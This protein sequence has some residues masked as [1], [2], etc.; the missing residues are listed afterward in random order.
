MLFF[1]TVDS[2]RGQDRHHIRH[3]GKIYARSY[4]SQ[5]L[6]V[7]LSKM[8]LVLHHCRLSGQVN[9]PALRSGQ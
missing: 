9:Y 6:H 4:G 5:A 8:E 2:G 7:N 3:S 1:C